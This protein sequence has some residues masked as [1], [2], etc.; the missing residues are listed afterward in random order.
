M[1][2]AWAEVEAWDV[3]WSDQHQVVLDRN[4]VLITQ[5]LNKTVDAIVKATETGQG[6]SLSEKRSEA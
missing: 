5:E 3:E 1:E 4:K 6:W 2:A